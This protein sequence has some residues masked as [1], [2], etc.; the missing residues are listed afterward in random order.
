MIFFFQCHI[1]IY[2]SKIMFCIILLGEK[3]KIL[4]FGKVKDEN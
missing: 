1:Y 3:V 4:A 2:I